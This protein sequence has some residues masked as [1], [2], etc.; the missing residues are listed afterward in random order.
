MDLLWNHLWLAFSCFDPLVFIAII[1]NRHGL[2]W[3]NI[4][5]IK[6]DGA[7]EMAISKLSIIFII[8]HVDSLDILSVNSDVKLQSFLGKRHIFFQSSDLIYNVSLLT[9]SKMFCHF[10]HAE[11]RK[12]T[13]EVSTAAV[14]KVNMRYE[15]ITLY[16]EDSE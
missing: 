7:A 2:D 12:L 8:S 5:L 4:L 10:Q 3:R 9:R 13:I 6:L 14:A 15:A 16:S 1:E 11:K